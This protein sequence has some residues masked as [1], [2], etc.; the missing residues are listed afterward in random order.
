[1][2]G[3]LERVEGQWPEQQQAKKM[4]IWGKESERVAGRKSNSRQDCMLIV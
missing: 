3:E 4:W 1:V 2:G